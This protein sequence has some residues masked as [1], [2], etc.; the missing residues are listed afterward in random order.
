MGLGKG[1]GRGGAR[2][3]SG[4]RRRGAG[5]K[6]QPRNLSAAR[7]LGNVPEDTLE[8]ADW[9]FRLLGAAMQE[10]ATDERM[11]KKAR[12]QELRATARAMVA[13]LPKARLHK[14]ERALREEADTITAPVTPKTEPAPPPPSSAPATPPPRDPPGSG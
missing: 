12:R 13:L 9:A 10:V 6:F 3:N 4:G 7:A 2:A 5:P 14:A 8:A 1:N 11:G